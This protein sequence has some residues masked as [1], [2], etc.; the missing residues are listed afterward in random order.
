MT[1]K[2]LSSRG[3]KMPKRIAHYIRMLTR[4]N[5]I[6]W[7]GIEVSQTQGLRPTTRATSLTPLG[8]PM[9]S[10]LA[11]RPIWTDPRT[12]K[13]VATNTWKAK[14]DHST[15]VQRLTLRERRTRKFAD[16]WKLQVQ[17][18]KSQSRIRDICSPRIPIGNAHA[19]ER[20]LEPG[21]RTSCHR[22]CARRLLQSPACGRVHQKA[23][24]G[25]RPLDNDRDPMK[26]S[27]PIVNRNSRPST[28]HDCQPKRQRVTR[29]G[30]EAIDPHIPL[31]AMTR[32]QKAGADTVTSTQ[33]MHKDQRGPDN[34]AELLG[35]HHIVNL[36]GRP[37]DEYGSSSKS[38]SSSAGKPSCGDLPIPSTKRKPS[39]QLN[40]LRMSSGGRNLSAPPARG[41]EDGPTTK[42]PTKERDGR[43]RKADNY[44]R[45][46]L[47]QNSEVQD[48][49]LGENEL[50]GATQGSTSLSG[51]KDR[52][53]PLPRPQTSSAAGAQASAKEGH[54]PSNPVAVVCAGTRGSHATHT[55]LTNSCNDGGIVANKCKRKGQ[56]GTTKART[57][58]TESGAIAAASTTVSGVK[59]DNVNAAQAAERSVREATKPDHRRESMPFAS[60]PIVPSVGKR[61]VQAG[62]IASKKQKP[63]PRPRCCKCSCGLMS[64]ECDSLCPEG[65]A[66]LGFVP[67]EPCCTSCITYLRDRQRR[68]DDHG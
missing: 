19:E 30:D 45:T 64:E 16:S 59:R 65:P 5:G 27:R 40:D 15:N 35:S 53:P 57:A 43:K 12:P 29:P 61:G 21:S 7:N 51:T 11:R 49:N 10:G 17:G 28:E 32:Q 48:K 26:R 60:K 8:G 58:E 56:C 66:H 23:P 34:Q 9:M 46:P 13:I 39:S 44:N 63:P 31:P 24:S 62:T 37:T 4:V 14:Q 25:R 54:Q 41:H 18:Y 6:K 22:M 1:S 47:E 67:G 20:H 42:K 33:P 36:E 68:L 2:A 55:K 38:A 52:E 50:P 3:R